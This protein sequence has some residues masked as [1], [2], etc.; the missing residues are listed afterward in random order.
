MYYRLIA[1]WAVCEG[2]LGGIIHG[3]QLPISG[4]IVGGCA[5]III[6]MIGYYVPDKN[7]IIKATVVVAIFKMMLSPF[8]PFPAYIAVFFQGLTGQLFFSRKSWFRLA[9]VIF[10]TLAL[11]ESAIQKILTTTLIYG[12]DFWKAINDFINGLTHQDQITNYSLWFA[13]VYVVLHIIAGFLIGKM[14]GSAPQSLHRWKSELPEMAP[15]IIREEINSPKRK[16]H[17]FIKTGM[18]IIWVILL[19]L[20]LQSACQI[21]EPILQPGD[22]GNILIRSLLIVFTWYFLVSPVLTRLLKNWLMKRK[23]REESTVSEILQIIPY[24]TALVEMCWQRSSARKGISRLRIF[25]KDVL[26]QSL[27]PDSEIK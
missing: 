11:F 17:R 23:E 5:V 15:V 1:L 9:C 3:F 12:V 24:T 25:M 8:S 27:L 4:L 26:V 2:V 6:C 19:V 18:L 20:Y 21:G 7:A 22:I 10:G 13:G 14:A 16:K